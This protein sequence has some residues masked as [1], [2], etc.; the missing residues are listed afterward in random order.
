MLE[1]DRAWAAGLFDGEGSTC[2]YR[3]NW[4]A[5]GKAKVYVRCCLGQK[6][7]R[8]LI[9]FHRI[10]LVG[11]IRERVINNQPFFD[12]TAG[13]ATDVTVVFNILAPYLGDVKITQLQQ[14]VAATT[15]VGGHYKEKST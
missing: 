15:H 9:K 10:V 6:D 1:T 3:G 14:A 2:N 13:A 12:W 7:P 4:D 11:N 5:T 8:V